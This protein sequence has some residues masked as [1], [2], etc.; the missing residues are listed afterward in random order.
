MAPSLLGL[1]L[2]AIAY[3]QRRIGGG[4]LPPSSFGRVLP[5]L[6]LLSAL[7]F[8]PAPAQAEQ[9][10]SYDANGNIVERIGPSGTTTYTY[11]ALDRL[12]S[13]AG[14]QKTQTL[15]YDANGNRLS[16]AA[17]NHSYTPNSDR[18]V[19]IAGQTVSLDAAGY[20]TQARGLGFVWDAAGQLK[21]VHQGSPT[22]T[23]L[24]SYAYDGYGRRLRK[25]TTAGAPQGAGTVL[26]LYDLNNHLLMEAN[27]AGTPLVTYVWRDDIPVSLIVHGSP[28]TV[29]YLETD[30]LNTPRAARNQQ[31]AVVWR[32]ESDAFGATL[33]NEDP[34]NTGTKTTI[35]LRFPGQ[36]FDKESGLHYNHHRYYDPKMGRYL[37]SDPIGLAGGLN[38]YLYVGGNPISNVDPLGLDSWGN[39]SSLTGTHWSIRPLDTQAMSKWMDDHAGTKSQHKCAKYVRQ[40]LEA[41]GAD[42]TGHP[43]AAAD[44]AN[45]LQNN[46]Y[47]PITGNQKYVPQQGDIT[48]IDRSSSSQYGHITEWDGS[49]WV[50]DFIQKNQ[51]PYRNPNFPMQVYRHPTVN[52]DCGCQ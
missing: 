14:P 38:T 23:L 48:V 9:T 13:E 16:D 35:N 30:H 50:S 52:E 20:I 36:Y 6:A 42:T 24:A 8:L 32:W 47:V 19:T 21:E 43:I 5:A 22:G 26:Y 33:A 34:G 27:A 25:V 51:S 10:L 37:S 18:Q 1:L 45:I 28:E 7:A 2:F 3:R 31:K 11:D 41:G 49:Q 46:G 29:L 44:Y 15:T 17:G 4:D 40:G 39:D 12:N